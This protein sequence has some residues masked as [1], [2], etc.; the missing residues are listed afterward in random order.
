MNDG[1]RVKVDGCRS[2]RQNADLKQRK[3]AASRQHQ[4]GKIPPIDGFALLGLLSNFD[5]G[6]LTGCTVM[7]SGG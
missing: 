2:D 1:I 7:V 4:V 6:M 5:G 3:E